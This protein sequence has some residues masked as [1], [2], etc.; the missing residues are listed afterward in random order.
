MPVLVLHFLSRSAAVEM[1]IMRE[2][3]QFTGG[4]WISNPGAIYP[5]LRWMEH[6]GLVTGEWRTPTDARGVSTV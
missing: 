6:R 1:S 2:L 3:E 4:A 5:L